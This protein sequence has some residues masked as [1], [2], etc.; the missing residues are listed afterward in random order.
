MTKSPEHPLLCEINAFLRETGIAEST[1]GQRASGDW[2]LVER[3]RNGG[4]VT[5]RMAA[6]IRAW[7]ASPEARKIVPRGKAA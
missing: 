4:D 3:L 2:Q 6:R 7:M 1:F 5:T